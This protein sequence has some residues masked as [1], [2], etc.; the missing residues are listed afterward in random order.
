M[1]P[2]IKNAEI[3]LSR[4]FSFSLKLLQL[5]LNKIANSPEKIALTPTVRACK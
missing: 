1:T 4:D 2:I 3:G 5:V